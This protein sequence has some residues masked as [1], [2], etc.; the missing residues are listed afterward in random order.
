[1]LSIMMNVFNDGALSLSDIESNVVI[2]HTN[3]EWD[4]LLFGLQSFIL[5]F[6]IFK[7]RL[8]LKVFGVYVPL[9]LKESNLGVLEDIWDNFEM[10]TAWAL[11]LFHHIICQTVGYSTWWGLFFL[12]LNFS[13]GLLSFQE[14]L[15]LFF[16]DGLLK[17]LQQIWCREYLWYEFRDS[18]DLDVL[19]HQFVLDQRVPFSFIAIDDLWNY[20]LALD[21]KVKM[22]LALEHV[23]QKIIVH[24]HNSVAIFIFLDRCPNWDELLLHQVKLMLCLKQSVDDESHKSLL[25][26]AHDKL[27][28]HLFNFQAQSIII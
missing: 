14:L 19:R 15:L 17:Y 9:I 13:C 27:C 28:H 2:L 10:E 20:L 3:I 23:I 25:T 18:F 26:V 5:Q 4:L 21:I 1:M 22:G 8:D 16:L 7:E 24:A 6:L 12:F 11:D